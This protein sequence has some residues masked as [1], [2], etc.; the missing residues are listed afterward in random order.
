MKHLNTF[1]DDDLNQVLANVFHFDAYDAEVKRL[2][3]SSLRR[4]GIPFGTI[5]RALKLTLQII[6]IAYL[7]RSAH[8]SL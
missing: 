7:S 3:S 1:P 2:V 5:F 6:V 8:L 4:S